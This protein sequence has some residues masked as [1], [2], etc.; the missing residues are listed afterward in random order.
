MKELIVAAA[1]LKDGLVCSIP[2]PGSHCDMF[3]MLA[4]MGVEIP[5]N[6]EEGFLTSEG[7]FVNRRYAM[8]IAFVAEQIETTPDNVMG[9]ELFSEDL[10]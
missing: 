10:W 1:L 2:P 6:C 5:V 7:R 4:S 8:L 9:L 3:R